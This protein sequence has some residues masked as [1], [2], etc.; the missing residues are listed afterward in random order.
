M[1]CGPNRLPPVISRVMME[2]PPITTREGDLTV[3]AGNPSAAHDQGLNPERIS[4]VRRHL[5]RVLS[6]KAFTGSKRSQDFL[7]LILEHALAGRLDNL[8]ERMIGAEMFGRPIDYDTANDAVVRVKANEVRRRLAQY[9]AEE[10][11]EQDPV[12]IDLPTGSYVPEF[13]WEPVRRPAAPETLTQAQGLHVAVRKA[14]NPSWIW[15]LA[16]AGAAVLA[17]VVYS[18]TNRTRP[19]QPLMGALSRLTFDSGFTTDGEVS[20]DGRLIAYASDRGN[21][22]NLDIYVQDAKRGSIAR[23]TNDPGDDYDPAFSP[24]GTQI[25]F[26]SERSGGGIYQVSSMRGEAHLVV[27]GGRRPRFSPDGR[28]LLYWQAAGGFYS[29]WGGLS[30]NLFTVEVSGGSSVPITQGCSWVNTGAVWSPDS[31]RI[32]FAGICKGR[33]GHWLASPDGKILEPSELY[34]FWKAQNHQSLD[35]NTA[36]V[37]DQWL[38]NPS[39]LL[40]PLAAGEDISYEASLPLAPNG[41]RSSGPVQPL[42]FGPSRI[43]HASASR[44]GRVILSAQEQ[45]S[46]I[47][48]LKVDSAGHAAGHPVPLRTGSLI[49]YE[50][51]LSRDGRH[52]VFVARQSGAWELHLIDL[53]NG[54]LTPLSVRLPSLS[55]PV[56]NSS[57]DKVY[58][59]GQLPEVERKSDYELTLGSAV[60]QMVLEKSLGGLWDASLDGGW[61]IT[62][63]QKQVSAPLG[64][65]YDDNRPLR[66]T[67]ALVDR[68]SHQVTPFLFN[69]DGNL[70]QAHFSHD[71]A[72][73]TFL[74]VRNHSQIYVTQFKPQETPKANWIAITDG[75]SW[76]DKPNFSFDDK[77]IYFTSD[78]DG[79][80]CIWAQRLTSG[81]RPSG[82]PIAV[83]HFHSQ[84]RS[85]ANLPIGQMS[86]A[87]GPGTLVFNQGEYTGNLWSYERR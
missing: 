56:F 11:T 65:S 18:V 10:G 25:A 83:Y 20:A 29:K 32:L 40:L 5:E 72:W 4:L 23:F 41:S 61:L 37:F 47:W 55:A 82:S 44:E 76:D 63:S 53:A 22:E 36:A 87:A 43:T 57:G 66:D 50:P 73:V 77:L 28:Y 45:S 33:S 85:L 64:I 84:R 46:N 21:G 31:K 67:L 38:D 19:N 2:A 6:G 27:P 26:R 58:Y 51:A 34:T 59:S 49:N 70:Y 80:R 74:S 17:V 86:L 52:V 35:R 54:E 13:H 7:R 3:S 8:R 24:D 78:R 81:M 71:G 79:F 68:N 30:A 15:I 12:W 48:M 75:A 42:V 1:K 60:P 16:A 69:P 62:H 39:R 14:G 9:Y